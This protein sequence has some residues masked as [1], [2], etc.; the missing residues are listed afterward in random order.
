MRSVP[1][2]TTFCTPR[3]P[4]REVREGKCIRKQ[5][6]ALGT[7]VP[8]LWGA[9]GALGAFKSSGQARE[10]FEFLSGF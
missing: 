4:W 6:G 2:P 7:D 3:T 5:R 9:G 1:V 10:E 8:G